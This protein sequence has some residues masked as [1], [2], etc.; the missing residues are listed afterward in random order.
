M[1]PSV[2]LLN[3]KNPKSDQFYNLSKRW[4]YDVVFNQGDHL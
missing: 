4:S 2:L 3:T 1:K